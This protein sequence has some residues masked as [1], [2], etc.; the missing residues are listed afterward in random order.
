MTYGLE[1]TFRVESCSQLTRQRFVLYETVLASR[2]NG[3]LVQMHRVEDPA[4]NASDLSRHQR[5]LVTKS[6]WKILRP[7]AQLFPMQGQEF[8]PLL[9]LVGRGVVIECRHSQRGIVEVV[10]LLDLSD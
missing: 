9:L 7:L 5:E 3:L 4:F 2:L 10:Q 6:W 8:P 1:A